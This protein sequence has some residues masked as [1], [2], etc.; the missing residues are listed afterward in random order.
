MVLENRPPTLDCGRTVNRVWQDLN[1][2]PDSHTRSCPGCRA[3][4][5]QLESL[6][7]ATAA[8]QHQELQHP[9]LRPPNGLTDKILA[10]AYSQMRRG[11]RFP[12]AGNPHGGVDISEMALAG[13]VRDAALAV[14]GVRAR[15]CRI[16]QI[17]GDDSGLLIHLRTAV[18]PGID[19]RRAMAFLRLRIR[20]A[21]EASVGIVPQTVHLT[22]EDLYDD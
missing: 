3:A 4:R 21:V 12:L 14:G 13:V 20:D 5:V 1:Q 18:A 11:A 22:V 17:P 10:V 9:G 6:S 15:R 2:P 7:T 8:L 19:I 16:E